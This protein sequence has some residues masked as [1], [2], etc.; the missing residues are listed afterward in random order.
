MTVQDLIDEL[1]RFDPHVRCVINEMEIDYVYQ[2]LIYKSN[3][4]ATK[5]V[6]NITTSRPSSVLLNL[7]KVKETSDWLNEKHKR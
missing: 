6:V 2:T 4:L 5:L 3:S 1:R 7:A